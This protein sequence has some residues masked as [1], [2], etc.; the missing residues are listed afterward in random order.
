VRKFCS[1]IRSASITDTLR[2]VSCSV[3]G[4][5]SVVSSTTFPAAGLPCPV[6]V[7]S[8]S[9]VMALV[10][11]ALGSDWFIGCAFPVRSPAAIN[12]EARYDDDWMPFMRCQSKYGGWALLPEDCERL[13]VVCGEMMLA[14]PRL[15]KRP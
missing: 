8:G 14:E 2:G 11:T 1:R 7:T 12:I 4:S 5:F 13:S 15:R 6:T 9:W 3:K 10:F